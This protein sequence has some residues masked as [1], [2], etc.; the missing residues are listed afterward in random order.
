MIAYAW[1]IKFQERYEAPPFDG[2][3][4]PVRQVHARLRLQRET[5]IV[6]V[7]LV[8][9]RD[10][11]TYGRRLDKL[12]A[13][14]YCETPVRRRRVYP[15]DSFSVLDPWEPMAPRPPPTNGASPQELGE[16]GQDLGYSFL[17]ERGLLFQVDWITLEEER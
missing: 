10:G 2:H 14:P 5:G 12:E 8:F 17:A 7:F 4:L 3:G 13:G 15:L 6:A 1:E 16:Y 11:S 9:D